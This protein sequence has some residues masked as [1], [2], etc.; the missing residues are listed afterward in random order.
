MKLIDWMMIVLP[1]FLGVTI[2]FITD[3]DPSP[4]RR[5]LTAAI[6]T[7]MAAIGMMLLHAYVIV[8]NRA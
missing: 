5:L 3:D 8:P 6:I 4:R 1:P 2:W 7:V